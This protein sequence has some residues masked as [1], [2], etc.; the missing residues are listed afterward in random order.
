MA[1]QAEEASFNTVQPALPEWTQDWSLSA[2]A[3]EELER[4]HAAFAEVERHRAEEKK[5]RKAAAAAA[6][7]GRHHPRIP[8]PPQAKELEYVKLDSTDESEDD[9]EDLQHAL[10]LSK[11]QHGGDEGQGSSR[12]PGGADD[13]R[14]DDDGDYD[15]VIPASLGL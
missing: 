2:F 6:N 5:E 10:F 7:A 4:Q 9:D 11:L 1:R 12:P 8:P 3:E 13:G 15:A 14:D